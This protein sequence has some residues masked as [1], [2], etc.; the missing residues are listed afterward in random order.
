[1]DGI[2]INTVHCVSSTKT[3]RFN[4]R[5]VEGSEKKEEIRSQA[6]GLDAMGP[7]RTKSFSANVIEELP[8]GSSLNIEYSCVVV[9]ATAT[10]RDNLLVDCK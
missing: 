10:R 5:V 6:D 3:R 2:E 4:I 8:T 9:T 1:M 7:I